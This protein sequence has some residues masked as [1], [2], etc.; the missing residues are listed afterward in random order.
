MDMPLPR[1][2]SRPQDSSHPPLQYLPQDSPFSIATGGF[3]SC[4]PSWNRGADGTD[5]CYKLYFPV[6]GKARLSLD[7]H[8]ATL[9]AGEAYLIPGYHLTRQEC[10]ARMDVY[11]L[12]FVPESLYLRFLLSH[13]ARIHTL[14][15][16][17]LKYWHATYLAIP[18]LFET[19]NHAKTLLCQLYYR[20]QAMLM[21]LVSS[22]LESYRLDH[23]ATNDPV[24]ERLQP[25]ILFMDQHFLENPP[26][27]EIARAAHL[28][29]NYFHRRFTAAFSITPFGYMLERRLNLGR[30]LLLSTN[31]PLSKI[32]EQTGFGSEFHFSKTFK[33]HCRLSP[34]Q[35]RRHA[36]P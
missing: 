6:L 32:A 14:S 20:V 27:A 23:F 33:K 24:F 1:A 7:T 3:H 19:Q 26:L 35:F 17:T 13:V 30:Q 28:A 12:H 5:R 2:T 16:P 21:D 25:A 22:T 18:Q 29:P 4:D 34:R 11:W 31:F 8:E 36:M 10:P 9:R 15:P